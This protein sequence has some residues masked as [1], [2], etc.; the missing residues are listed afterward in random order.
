MT[1]ARLVMEK[2][3]HVLIVGKGAAR[4]AREHKLERVH[5]PK[6][7]YTPAV[8]RP[9]KK[10]ELAHG[11]VGAIALDT[12]GRLASATS[13]GGLLGKQAGRERAAARVAPLRFPSKVGVT[14]PL[15][16]NAHRAV[17]WPGHPS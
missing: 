17:S 8:S 2:T 5:N 16:S 3:P 7:Y 6:A 4:I 10:G 11:T 14:F 9:V 12:E 15:Y 13:T 1:A